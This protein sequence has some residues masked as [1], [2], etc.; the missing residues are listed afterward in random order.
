MHALLLILGTVLARLVLKS[1]CLVLLADI[2]LGGIGV[3]HIHG[4]SFVVARPTPVNPHKVR[5]SACAVYIYLRVLL[6]V[7]LRRA[8]R[9]SA[10]AYSLAVN[11]VALVAHNYLEVRNGAAAF[12]MEVAGDFDQLY[13]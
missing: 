1:R 4:I 6:A 12:D 11:L 7:T 8:N 5:S 3:L 13:P 9:A 10:G 2:V